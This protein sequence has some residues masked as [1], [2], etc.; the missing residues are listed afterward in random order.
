M[1]SVAPTMS[2]SWAMMNFA[3]WCGM[4]PKAV[5]KRPAL[6]RPRA[7]RVH[8]SAAD[9]LDRRS[10]WP[11]GQEAEGEAGE[12]GTLCLRSTLAS[13]VVRDVFVPLSDSFS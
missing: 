6:S 5:A 13:D 1:T 9:S 10:G 12:T 2:Y 3:K 7:V 11:I 8:G 4:V